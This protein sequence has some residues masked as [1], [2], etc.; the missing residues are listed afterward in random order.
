MRAVQLVAWEAEPEL[1][2]IPVPEPGPGEVLVAVEAAGLCRSDLHIMSRPPGTIPWDLP[3]TLGHEN[4]GTIAALGPGAAGVAI[5]DRV[6]VYG[7]W[8]C[9]S[10]WQC[11]RGAENLCPHRKGRGAGCGLDGGLAQY[12]LVPSTRL[13]VPIGDLDPVHAAPLTDAALSSYHAIKQEL[14]RLRPGSTAVVIGVGGLGHL[15]IQI[16]RALS[17]ARLVAIDPR[18]SSRAL[19]L[20]AGADAALDSTGLEPADVRAEAGGGATLVLDLVGSDETLRLAVS[21]LEMGAHLSVVGHAGGALPA[22][23]AGLPFDTSVS[24]PS[25][26]TLPELR[27]VVALARAGALSVEVEQL[28]LGQ[29]IDGYQRLRDG[30]VAA[31]A[32][33]VP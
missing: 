21:V 11:A 19:A 13:L 9:G 32:V 14:P 31:R 28:E 30:E 4:A 10:C 7:P 15:A 3:F 5:G 20:D 26:G 29:A 2:E 25:W 12:L 23:F 24:R 16:L 6:V 8:G 27:E 1:R 18:A 33:V 22:P 17:P